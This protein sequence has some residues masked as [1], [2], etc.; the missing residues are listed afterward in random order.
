MPNKR[1][2]AIHLPQFY[3][4]PENDEWWGKGF[5]EW[6]NV[7]QAKPR[8]F[9]HYQPHIPADLGFYDLR[10]KQSR[11]SQ[12]ELA[13]KYGI[14]GFCYYHYWF[15]GHLLMEKPVEEM[16]R[17]NDEK[18]PFMLCWANENWHRNWSGRDNVIL[19]EQ[20]YSEEDDI[21]HFKYLLPY[22]KDSRYIRVNGKPV[23]AIYKVQYIP[24]VERMIQTFQRM[25][26]EEGFELY[27]CKFEAN[28]CRGKQFMKK[29]INAAIDFQPIN[30]DGF[31]VKYTFFIKA[32]NRLF[33]F[34]KKGYKYSYSKYV[35][36]R[37]NMPYTTEYKIFP[38]VS[39]CWDNSSRR[40]GGIYTVFHGSTPKLFRKWLRTIYRNFK[41]FSDEENLIF[42]NAWNEWAEGCHLEPDL[43]Y[44]DG[45]LNAIKTVVE[46]ETVSKK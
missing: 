1:V 36:Y 35:K 28:G 31:C 10:L 39:P 3:P 25:A 16:L 40:V 2:I 37:C 12:Q 4:F 38:C 34:I 27:I 8:F 18:M 32:L 15:N 45:Y 11:I 20:H 22:F 30:N 43:K 5:T 9:K 23:F 13:S 21:A 26:K 41:P 14:Y 7:V 19:M 33:P 17:D 24:D 29:G 6:R 44:G 42:I 46:A